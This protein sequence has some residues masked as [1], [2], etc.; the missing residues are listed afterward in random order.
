MGLHFVHFL[1]PSNSGTRCLASVLSQVCG[2]SY[3]LPGP[4]CLVSW[5]CNESTVSGVPCVSSGE[6]ISDCDPPGG[7]QPSRI[8]EDLVS[9]WEPAHSLEDA[10]SGSLIAPCPPA[11]AV[12]C[13]P[14]CLRQGDGLVCSWLALLWYSLNPLFCERM[15]LCLR[16]FQGNVLF[17]PSL[18]GYPTVWVAI[19]H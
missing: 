19:S 7:C 2:V 8:P 11:L 16:A 4:S 9:N 13:L 12:A 14:L 10:V 6:L 17:F 3:H 15:R 1:G 18:S 5:V